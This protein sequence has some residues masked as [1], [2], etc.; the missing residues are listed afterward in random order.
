MEPYAQNPL[1]YGE[2]QDPIFWPSLVIRSERIVFWWPNMNMNIFWLPKNDWIRIRILF[3]FPKMTEYEYHLV[4]KKMAEY[5]Y[6]Y[7]SVFEKHRIIRFSNIFGLN[8]SNIFEYIRIYSNTEL[9]AHLWTWPIWG[10][11]RVKKRS[12]AHLAIALFS[13]KQIF[14]AIKYQNTKF[15]SSFYGVQY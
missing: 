5:E 7:Y 14:Q 10:M 11:G 13:N 2:T 1:N 6:E 8:Y 3:G 15:S 9:F 12:M 4:S